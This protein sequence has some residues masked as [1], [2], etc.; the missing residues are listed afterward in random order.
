[1]T[2][3]RRAFPVSPSRRAAQPSRRAAQF[4][5]GVFGL[6]L[7]G[8]AVADEES[9][10]APERLPVVPAP[11]ASLRAER[12]AGIDQAV[13]QALAD[14]RMPGC[15]VAIGHRGRIGWLKA[16]GNR[17]TQPEPMAMTVNTVFDLAS[18]TKP[19]ATATSVMQLIE[20]GQIRLRDRLSDHIP[21]FGQE[22]K[23]RITIEQMLTHMSGLIADNPLGDYLEGSELAFE[24][25]WALKL[26]APPGER[27]FTAM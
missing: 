20:R 22:G 21:E 9:R 16:Y 6:V 19:I 25:I 10:S 11:H 8:T 12:L 5:V 26:Q 17:Q 13:E 15:V 7:L 1:M 2:T 14:R 23:E 27:S 3:T 4:L 18:L 24:K